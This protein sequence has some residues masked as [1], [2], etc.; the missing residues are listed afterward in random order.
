MVRPKLAIKKPKRPKTA[1]NYFQLAV[2]AKLEG[3]HATCG[4]NEKASRDIG[5]S[6]KKLSPA[7]KRPFHLQAQ[8]DRSRYE[9][10]NQDYLQWLAGGK[11]SVFE[12]PRTP[13]ATTPISPIVTSPRTSSPE[14]APLKKFSP[15]RRA[16]LKVEPHSANAGLL[17]VFDPVSPYQPSPSLTLSKESF[18]KTENKTTQILTPTPKHASEAMIHGELVLDETKNKLEKNGDNTMT[19]ALDNKNDLSL[20]GSFLD[21]LCDAP[22]LFDDDMVGCQESSDVLDFFNFL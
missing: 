8:A 19:M 18:F 6:W 16:Q 22:N 15:S 5:K 7:E 3:S 4:Y 9:R 20:G 17:S 12:A 13:S 2:K 1:Y 14:P 11:I 21:T 10:Q